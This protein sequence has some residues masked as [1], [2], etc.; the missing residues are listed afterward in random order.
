MVIVRMENLEIGIK[1]GSKESMSSN[2]VMDKFHRG[3]I[4]D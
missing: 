1:K 4:V 3:W 2:K